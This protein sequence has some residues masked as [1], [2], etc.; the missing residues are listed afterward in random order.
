MMM[1]E[2]FPNRIRSAAVAVTTTFLWIVIYLGAQLFPMITRYSEQKIG[3]VGGA[4]WVFSFICILS[5]L[6]GWK[7]LPETKGRTLEQIAASW[8]KKKKEPAS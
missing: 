2:I 1:S 4:F 3:S 5:L 6:F 7:M 8:T